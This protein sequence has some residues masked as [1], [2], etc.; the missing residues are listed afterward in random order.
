MD[1]AI[2]AGK[3]TDA[4]VAQMHEV[5]ATWSQRPTAEAL[6]SLRGVSTITAMTVLTELRR[7]EAL[8]YASR[9]GGL[10]RSGFR[11][12][13]VRFSSALGCDHQDRQWSR[14]PAV[15]RGGEGVSVPGEK[16]GPSASQGRQGPPSGAGVR[17]GGAETFCAPGM[18]GSTDAGRR[19]TRWSRRSRA[20]SSASSGPSPVRWKAS[21]TAPGRPPE[22]IHDIGD[23]HHGWR[24]DAAPPFEPQLLARRA[25]TRRLSRP[26]PLPARRRFGIGSP[27][28]PQTL[29]TRVGPP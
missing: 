8:R 19:R 26:E 14:S 27:T 20:S 25:H 15:D 21:L 28:L 5:L 22:R 18:R 17:L 1:A 11:R 12:T 29:A 6:M 7:S 2:A 3:R 9:T 10:P 23:Q 24:G 16:D 4:L 13:L